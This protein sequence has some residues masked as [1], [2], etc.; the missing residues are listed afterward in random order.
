MADESKGFAALMGEMG[1]EAPARGPSV[2]DN[3]TGVI[4]AVDAS[5][6]FVD[7]GA[8]AEAILE[9]SELDPDTPPKVGDRIKAF[10]VSRKGDEILL[11]MRLGRGDDASA[12]QGAMEA[13]I[14]VFGK[15][16]GVNKG[17]LE[18][19][20][21]GVR[22]FCPLSQIDIARVEDPGSFVGKELE[23][24]VTRFEDEGGGRVNIV[25]SRRVLLEAQRSSLAKETLARLE[26]G[27]VV[28]GK[29]SRIKEFGAFVDLG[30]LEGLLHKS[31]LGFGRNVKVENS[32]SIGDVVEAQVT[33]IE[34]A[35]EPGRP[36]RISLSLKAL[37]K[38]PFDDLGMIKGSRRKGR[39]M[40]L[41]PFGAF[42][43][44]GDG[45]EGL[46]HVSEL[47]DRRVNHPRE[48]VSVGDTVDVVVLEVDS[49]RRRVG[50]SIKQVA[51]Q[52]E[53]AQASGFK[54]AS[55]NSLGT[56]A[57]LMKKKLN[58]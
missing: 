7:V 18:V 35:T 45:I 40:R 11:K 52:E 14:P 44:L 28:R 57:D 12:I 49:D 24:R 17:G 2:G 34:P 19:D 36:D 46:V 31:E 53:A 22:A 9:K 50:L 20:V 15:I 10:V 51:S 5:T 37:Q 58:R 21:N 25:L 43:E 39:V 41:E 3:V 48:V 27:A 55:T 23:F 8:K 26:L 56:F 32:V 47:S 54:P 42:I 16:T 29:V 6:V 33:K 30:G 38:D 4:V 1:A 13:Q